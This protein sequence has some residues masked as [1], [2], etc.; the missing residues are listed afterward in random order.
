[1]VYLEEKW[2]ERSIYP[3]D[4]VDRQRCA[5]LE[6]WADESLTG[7]AHWAVWCRGDDA[8]QKLLGQI[9]DEHPTSG[10]RLQLAIKSRMLPMIFNMLVAKR[11]GGPEA[12]AR[13]FESQLDM[14]AGLL[15]HQPFL[16]GDEP[17]AADFAVVGQLANGLDFPGGKAVLEREHLTRMVRAL[18]AYIQ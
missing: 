15:A 14:L 4:P 2:P 11:R 13:Y 3:S 10:S 5:L 7:P 9:A 1:M 17:T 16:F 6:D 18:L 8:P 12:T